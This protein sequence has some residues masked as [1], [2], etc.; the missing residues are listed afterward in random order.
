MPHPPTH[1]RRAFLKTAA[2][3]ASAAMASKG[4]PQEKSAAGLAVPVMKNGNLL[5]SINN[6][7]NGSVNFEIEGWPGFHIGPLMPALTVDGTSI[8][9]E[10]CETSSEQN[11]KKKDRQVFI[12]RGHDP[13]TR[14]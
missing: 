8:Q 6:E 10:D 3:V 4:W 7:P 12:L 2:T 9:P 13:H 5:L 14:V 1:S 11:P